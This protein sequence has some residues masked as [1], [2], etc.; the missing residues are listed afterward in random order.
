[1]VPYDLLREGIVVLGVV[2]LVVVILAGVFSSPQYPPVTSKQMGYAE[3]LATMQTAATVLA[4]Q[5]ETETYGPPYNKNGAP[6]EIFG[7]APASWF[8]VQIPINAKQEFVLKPLEAV[9]KINKEVAQALELYKSAPLKQQQEWANNYNNM[10][11]KVTQ[12]DGAFEGMK[13]GDF[14]PVPVLVEGI[15]MLSKS[16]LLE[17][18]QNMT[19]WNPYIFNY[20]NS[21]L[22]IQNSGLNT[23]ATKLDMQGTQMGISHETGPWPGAWWLWPYAGLYQIPPML[24]SNN[25]DIQVGAIMIMLFLILL[26]LPFI[27]VLNRIPYWI[28]LYKLFWRD[29]YKRDKNK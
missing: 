14:G 26:F 10:L 24:T 13:D 19:A 7:I 28:P 11:A 9:A 17:A 2:F 29:W 16:G 27:P 8:G 3:P 21:L 12:K 6:Q 15:L 1:M 20:T 5:C 23:V 25:G 18:A 4:G 22:F